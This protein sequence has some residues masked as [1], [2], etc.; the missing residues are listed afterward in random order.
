[1]KMKAFD[2]NKIKQTKNKK[3]K[4]PFHN[5]SPGEIGDTRYIPNILQSSLQQ[6]HSQHQLKWR[7]TQ[8]N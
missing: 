5:I 2:K 7:E 6:T 3:Q 1:M 4:T 8:N